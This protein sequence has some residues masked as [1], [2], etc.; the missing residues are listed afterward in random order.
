[1]YF[2]LNSREPHFL[3]KFLTVGPLGKVVACC[4]AF[5][6]FFSFFFFKWKSSPSDLTAQSHYKTGQKIH[7][8]ASATSTER[9]KKRGQ[10]R[11]SH[12]CEPRVGQA[13]L[14]LQPWWKKDITAL[15]L[16][17]GHKLTPQPKHMNTHAPSWKS[18]SRCSLKYPLCLQQQVHWADTHPLGTTR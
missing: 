1:M 12:S 9:K 15:Q 3:Y 11:T 2:H 18:S 5:N 13:S 14:A 8:C 4:L 17:W 6:A 10:E 16:K 7:F